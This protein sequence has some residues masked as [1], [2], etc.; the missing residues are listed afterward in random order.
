[1][2]NK[3]LLGISLSLLLTM[4]VNAQ[5]RSNYVSKNSLGQWRSA[6]AHR[7]ISVAPYFNN[8]SHYYSYNR[9]PPRVYNHGRSYGYAHSYVYGHYYGSY[10]GH[11]RGSGPSYHWEY[12][13]TYGYF[14]L[15][16]H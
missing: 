1:M 13:P 12:N 5:S 7:N 16:I 9:T 8:H 14:M 15:R 10:H 11:H 4:T 3:I 2:F 6:Q